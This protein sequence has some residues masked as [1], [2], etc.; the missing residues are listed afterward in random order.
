M[1]NLGIEIGL[2][3][4]THLKPSTRKLSRRH[5]TTLPEQRRYVYLRSAPKTGTRWVEVMAFAVAKTMCGEGSMCHFVS[6]CE[7]PR[8]CNERGFHLQL[9]DG[10]EVIFGANPKHQI[11]FLLEANTHRT[12]G[13]CSHANYIPQSLPCGLSDRVINDSRSLELCVH[14]CWRANSHLLK[15]KWQNTHFL[16]ISRDPRNTVVSACFHLGMGGRKLQEC[17]R[18]HYLPIACWMRFRQLLFSMHPDMKG[19]HICY[20]QLVQDTKREIQKIAKAFWLAPS[21]AQR[22]AIANVTSTASLSRKN[23]RDISTKRNVRDAGR[24]NYTKYGL[25]PQITRWMDKI[26][27]KLRFVQFTLCKQHV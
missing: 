1:T 5:A 2:Q 7:S 15:P 6:A 26:Y 21:H 12:T 18:I 11:P 10:R 14:W 4:H 24:R 20:E 27:D 9:H 19:V 23:Q 3:E 8:G 16:H 17:V 22:K 13:K 25:S